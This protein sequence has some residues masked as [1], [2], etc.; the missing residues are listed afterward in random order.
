MTILT[1]AERQKYWEWCRQHIDRE[2]IYRVDET[3]PP[4]PGAAPGSTYVWQ[5][6]SRRNTLNPAFA[7]A[8]GFLFWDHF[9]PV[10]RQQPFQVCACHPSGP[11]IGMAI[12]AIGRQLGIRV[13]LFLARREPKSFGIDNWFDG[14]VN[15]L[16]VLL[17][18]DAASSAPFL[19]LAASRIRS[20]LGLPLHK[21]YFTTV[22]KIGRNFAKDSQHTEGLLDNEL[23]SL[24]TMN[25]FCKTVAEFKDR[26]GHAPAWTGLVK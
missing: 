26:Y 24:Y 18:D 20:K 1:Y 17:V 7:R 21:N 4:I 5:V 15:K 9:L 19:R 13:N 8:L 10:Y 2:G 14:H 6:Y 12:S 11:P 16:P 23:V 25:N 22:N 3:H